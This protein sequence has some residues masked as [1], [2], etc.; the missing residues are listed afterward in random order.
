VAAEAS[1]RAA[2]V[3]AAGWPDAPADP[4]RAFD[5]WL[6][7]DGHA[8]NPGATADLVTAALF[9]ALRDGTIG[10]PLESRPVAGGDS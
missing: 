5:A 7:A 2:E 8:R 4:L 3:L 6:R 10:L 1:R 9:A